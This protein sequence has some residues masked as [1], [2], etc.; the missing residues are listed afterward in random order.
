MYIHICIYI[1]TYT[2]TYTYILWIHRPYPR[3]PCPAATSPPSAVRSLRDVYQQ[4]PRVHLNEV[5]SSGVLPAICC[6]T[7]EAYPRTSLHAHFADCEPLYFPPNELSTGAH[8]AGSILR[9]PPNALLSKSPGPEHSF[10]S[11]L[12]NMQQWAGVPP[13][14]RTPTSSLRM[15]MPLP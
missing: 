2:L 5:V 15:Y 11:P 10:L 9:A 13:R 4:L 14:R 1:Y 6:M 7:S 12:L 3:S 8:T